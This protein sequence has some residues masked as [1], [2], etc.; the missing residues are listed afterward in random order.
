MKIVELTGDG[1]WV[2]EGRAS[3]VRKNQS[4]IFGD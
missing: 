3:A 2:I 4:F 1:N